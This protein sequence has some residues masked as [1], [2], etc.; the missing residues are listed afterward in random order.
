MT[1]EKINL[2]ITKKADKKSVIYNKMREYDNKEINLLALKTAKNV[3]FSTTK[4][5]GAT[6]KPNYYWYIIKIQVDK[7]LEPEF[8]FFDNEPQAVEAIGKHLLEIG[9]DVRF[10][11]LSESVKQQLVFKA[12]ESFLLFN[13][14]E[15]ISSL[16]IKEQHQEIQNTIV[17]KVTDSIK[18]LVPRDKRMKR[19][20]YPDSES[21]ILDHQQ[22][23][24]GKI[25][26]IANEVQSNIDDFSTLEPKNGAKYVKIPKNDTEWLDYENE[27]YSSTVDSIHSQI[28]TDKSPMVAEVLSISH[29]ILSD[30]KVR[31]PINSN[32]YHSV[33]TD[34]NPQEALQRMLEQGFDNQPIYCKKKTKC[35]ATLKLSNA[36]N[37]LSEGTYDILDFS[38]YEQLISGKVLTSPPPL[39]TSSDTIDHIIGLFDSGCEAILFEFNSNIWHSMGFDVSVSS[40]LEDGIHIMTPH[41]IAAYYLSNID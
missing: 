40:T 16:D 7:S 20:W 5:G 15:D 23:V 31:K 13:G 33:F 10:E 17:K 9:V 4:I 22:F 28:I 14:N 29:P 30:E 12:P 39:F 35:V 11:Q 34:S 6:Y 37:H 41:D 3:A 32:E 19:K 27:T 26:Q 38:H 1:A 25:Q 2:N 18:K 8:E 21:A 36:L 24:Q